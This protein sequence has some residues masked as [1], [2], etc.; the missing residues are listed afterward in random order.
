[1]GLDQYLKKT[2]SVNSWML[3]S[4]QEAGLKPKIILEDY[5][6]I[7][8]EQISAIVENVGSWRKCNA[9]HHWFVENIQGGEDDCKEY[10]LSTEQLE[11][12]L[13]ICEDIWG[14][15][16]RN[17]NNHGQPNEAAKEYAE[18]KLPNTEGF[19]FG[20]QEYDKDYF[21]W[22][23]EPTIDMLKPIVE[24]GNS[25]PNSYKAHFFHWYTYQSSW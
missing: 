1:M 9:I 3:T 2:T 8:V 25:N 10:E 22:Q 19:F 4:A 13:K 20:N 7:E 21:E 23:I 14:N 16:K 18:E 6:G 12:L 15:Y 11:E 17:S 24:A 5:P